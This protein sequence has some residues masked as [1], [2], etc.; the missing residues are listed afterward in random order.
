VKAA[1]W[2][3]WWALGVSPRQHPVCRSQVRTCRQ[4]EL[5]HE[6]LARLRAAST[7]IMI[8]PVSYETVRGIGFYRQFLSTRDWAGFMQAGR[9]EAHRALAAA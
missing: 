9:I 2:H 1:R 7:V 8:E 6:N 3:R 4:I 5:A